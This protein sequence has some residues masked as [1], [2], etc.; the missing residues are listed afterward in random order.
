MKISSLLIFFQFLWFMIHIFSFRVTLLLLGKS[1]PNPFLVFSE[2][3]DGFSDNDDSLSPPFFERL[4]PSLTIFIDSKSLFGKFRLLNCDFNGSL[5]YLG[6]GIPSLESSRGFSESVRKSSRVARDFKCWP[7]DAIV[8]WH[9][10]NLLAA[11]ASSF[12]CHKHQDI[13]RVY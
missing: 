5:P 10:A 3:M 12:S 8:F 13:K 6:P 2:V 11:T 4:E 7:R 9:S 1:F